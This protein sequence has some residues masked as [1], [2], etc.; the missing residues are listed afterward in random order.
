MIHNF[1]INLAYLESEKVNS[2]PKN[3]EKLM[4]HLVFQNAN[5]QDKHQI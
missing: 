2:G 4:I 5:I 1:N 3:N